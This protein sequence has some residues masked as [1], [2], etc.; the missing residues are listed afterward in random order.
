MK[1]FLTI[2]VFC[3]FITVRAQDTTHNVLALNECGAPFYHG[4]ASGDPLTDRVIIWTRVTPETVQSAPV[5]VRWRVCRDTGM[6]QVVKTGSIITS[7]AADYT[8]KVDVTG[9]RPN[10]YYYYDF[11]TNGRYSVRGRTH[12]TPSSG[13][14]T[15][16]FAT[17]SCGNWEDGFFNAY[18]R[19]T[20][21]NDVEAVI[22]LGDYI[23]EYKRGDFGSNIAERKNEPANEIV[24]LQ[25]YRTRYSQYRLDPDL[26][27]CHQQYPWLF[28]WDDHEFANDA[29]KNGAENHQP[30][31]E[32]N[33]ESRKT[34]AIQA[35]LEWLPV[36]TID[37]ANPS[38]IYRSFSYGN[39]IK[40]IFLDTRIFARMEQLSV[41][42]PAFDNEN[43]YLIGQQQMDWL[44]NELSTSTAKWNIICQQVMVAPL[45][46]FGVPVNTD[47]WDGYPA[48][49]DRLIKGLTDR[50]IRNA[51]ILTG[52]FHTAWANDIPKANY[53]PFFQ[54]GSAGV[55]FVTTSVT[56]QNFNL[57]IAEE[58]IQVLNP[59][60]RY[61]DIKNHG[62]LLL[63]VSSKRVTG[64][65]YYMNSIRTRN[66]GEYFAKA[67]YVQGS[68]RKVETNNR[69]T[70]SIIPPAPPAPACPVPQQQIIASSVSPVAEKVSNT[71]MLRLISLYPN[72]FSNLIQ[73]QIFAY[74]SSPLELHIYSIQGQLL[75]QHILPDLTP[76]INYTSVQI[77][78]LAPGTYSFVFSTNAGSLKK[79]LVRQ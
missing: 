29:Y 35:W 20:N 7:E 9:L 57:P 72:P 10:T 33:W 26:A 30:G 27:N 32:G 22:C 71:E 61:A 56:S 42:D 14:T 75:H 53:N 59:H 34:N 15:R 12:T 11:E 49:R 58:L 52:D 28:V 40:F 25:D 65:W 37:T 50:N 17:V 39:L 41:L 4:V 76:G 8:V 70:T 77:P 36:R 69:K 31:Q 51:V 6:T 13:T 64:E 1:L 78:D 73:A 79:I 67:A 68:S 66:N 44:L 46:A 16:R 74:K 48:E 18:N 23:Y 43:R 21:R 2:I 55:E 60:V 62:Y 47:S 19:I 5:T 63:N 38:K 54:T 45:T 24:T 3:S